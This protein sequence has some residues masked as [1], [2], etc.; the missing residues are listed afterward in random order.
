MGISTVVDSV[1]GEDRPHYGRV[2]WFWFWVLCVSVRGPWAGRL[3]SLL[4]SLLIAHRHLEVDALLG[5]GLQP[6]M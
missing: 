4:L 3:F 5:V 1:G 6:P 2:A